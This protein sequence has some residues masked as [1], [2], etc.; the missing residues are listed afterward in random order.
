MV[1]KE[2]QKFLVPLIK[3]GIRWQ[4]LED[5]GYIYLLKNGF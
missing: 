3:A 4:V 2:V 5:L 1:E